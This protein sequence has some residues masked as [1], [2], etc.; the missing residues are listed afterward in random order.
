MITGR[1]IKAARALLGWDAADLAKVAQLSRETV[2][3]IENDLVQAREGTLADIADAF[4]NHGIEF[5]GNTGVQIRQGSVYELRGSEGFKK[6]MDEIYMAACDPSAADGKKPLCVSNVDDRLFMKH[7]G[8][9]MLFHAKRMD[10]LKKV[11]VHVLVREQDYF[12]IPGGKYLEYRWCPKQEA[13]NVPFYV[14]GDKLAILIFD[15][16][17]ELQII[18]ISS[19]SVAKVYREQFSILWQNSK[20]PPQPLKNKR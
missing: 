10:D 8:D 11:K 18:V 5:I 17:Q 3:N 13:G 1:Q 2:S 9:Y 6:L 12:T 14:Y 4:Y 20:I 16:A 15:E 19:R 7:L